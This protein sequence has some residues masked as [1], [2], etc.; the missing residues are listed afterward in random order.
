MA[1]KQ[2]LTV[3]LLAA[4]TAFSYAGTTEAEKT[5][6]PEPLQT[7]NYRIVSDVSEEYAQ[8]I[9]TK[10]EAA[11]ALY[12]SVFRFDLKKLGARM[13]VVIYKNKNSFD[14]YLKKMINQTREDFVYIHYSDLV[15]CELV[16][17][18]KKDEVD[19]NASLLHQGMI[20]FVKAFVPATPLWLTEGMAA[21]IE[22]SEYN[23]ETNAFTLIKN[24]SWLDSLKAILKEGSEKKYI[25]LADLLVIE[26]DAASSSLDTFYPEAWG[27]VYFLL[28]AENKSYNRLI[29]DAM[30]RI[31]PRLSL[32]EN[33]AYLKDMLSQWVDPAALETDY[34]TFILSIK[35]YY[36]EVLEG[37]SF[38]T[39]KDYANAE[40]HFLKAIDQKPN[41]YFAYYYMGL[42]KYSAAK[43]PEAEDYYKKALSMGAEK[44]LTYYALGVNAYADNRYENAVEY[45]KEAKTADA[46]NYMEKADKILNRIE[47]EGDSE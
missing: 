24:L 15:K 30:N 33:S 18:Q 3:M 36:D 7:A 47:A 13:K 46:D 12:N 5:T 1:R 39:N 21:Y 41:D 10:M 16:G 11:L 35:T 8:E 38:Y 40:T 28:N 27:F 19:F 43:Y 17:Y 22:T 14:A 23:T 32:T 42:I 6:K 45:L 9:G 26:K 20:Q 2:L 37:I 34:K 4:V 31:D 44:A 25:P 29:W